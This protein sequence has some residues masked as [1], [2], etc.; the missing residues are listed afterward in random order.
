[1]H[2]QCRAAVNSDSN[3]SI[4]SMQS[5]VPLAR[6]SSTMDMDFVRDTGPDPVVTLGEAVELYSPIC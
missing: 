2:T 1:M 3:F 4:M 5:M 6:M